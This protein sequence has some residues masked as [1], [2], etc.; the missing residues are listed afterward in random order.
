[1]GGQGAADDH[2]DRGCEK[3]D[4][5]P[6]GPGREWRGRGVQVDGRYNAGESDGPLNPNG[7]PLA[8]DD[9]GARRVRQDALPSASVS[10]GLGFVIDNVIDRCVLASDGLQ[11]DENHDSGLEKN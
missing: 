3:E 9:R 11:P 5:Q 2:R 4:R 8:Q 7:D 1:M 10:S 6:R